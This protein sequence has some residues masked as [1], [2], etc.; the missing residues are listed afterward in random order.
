MIDIETLGTSPKAPIIQI[1]AVAFDI[2]GELP[3]I[4]TVDPEYAKCFGSC[5]S[6]ES[7][8]KLG[9]HVEADT[10]RWWLDTDVEL[11]RGILNATGKQY[12]ACKILH[13]FSEWMQTFDNPCVWSNGVNFDLVL[14]RSAYEDVGQPVPW[15]FRNERDTRTLWSFMGRP[16][17]VNND[18]HDALADAWC[19]AIQVQKAVAL[20]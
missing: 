12:T 20:L 19:Q 7:M 10:L 15:S 9:R 16:E 17:V 8:I 14:L 5:I 11:L 4:D 13:D 18:K 2:P 1:G 6:L 3:P